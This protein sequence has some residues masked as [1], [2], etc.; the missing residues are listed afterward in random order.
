MFAVI[1][2]GGKQYRVA[3]DDVI[4]V[5]KL[6]AEAGDTHVFGD[7]LMIGDGGSV[8]LGDGLAGAAVTGEVIEQRRA[9]KIVIFKKRQRNTYRR[10]KGHRQHET[11]VRITGIR[12]GGASA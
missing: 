1:R 4:V 5:E 7:V 3:A 10:K 6:K 11:V 12:A 8:T 9:A 2:T